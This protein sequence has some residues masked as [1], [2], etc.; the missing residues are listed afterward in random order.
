MIRLSTFLIALVLLLASCSGAP[1]VEIPEEVASLENVT[2]VTDSF[3][4]VPE[5]NPERVARFGETEDVLIGRIGSSVVDENGRV[6]LN[7][8]DQKVIHVFNPDGNRIRQ[9]GREGDGPGEFRSL[10]TLRISNGFL[11]AMDA[12]PRRISRFTLES[13]EFHSSISF[14]ED[15]A[16]VEFG[17][18]YTYFARPD[19]SYLIFFTGPF[20]RDRDADEMVW[21]SAVLNP[22][23][24]FEE[25]AFLTIPANEWLVIS[26]E[27]FMR[28]FP[29]PYGRKSLIAMNSD[30]TLY[31]TWSEHLLIKSYSM[32]GQYQQAIYYPYPKASLDRSDVMSRVKDRSEQ[33]Q[34]HLRNQNMPS[35]WPAVDALHV[36]DENRFW[37]SGV[38]ENSEEWKWMVFGPG[39]SPLAT[40]TWPR[41]TAIRHIQDGF[42]YAYETDEETGLAEIVKYDFDL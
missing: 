15:S 2:V 28:A 16:P 38:T 12:S 3:E 22:D 21:E 14:S 24:R 37:V 19:S 41:S 29:A 42:I 25:D 5:L 17:F 32:E 35:T 4:D 39:G 10:G 7:D 9:L 1:D 6:F 13:L 33:D 20:M 40:F 27:G 11:H 30:G 31:H 23:E 8:T 36:D 26:G 34:S 18:P